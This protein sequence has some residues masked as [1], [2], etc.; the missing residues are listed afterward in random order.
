MK[1]N[2]LN[3][4]QIKLNEKK[5]AVIS[6]VWAPE[7]N[8]KMKSLDYEA[9]GEFKSIPANKERVKK[10]GRAII[11]IERPNANT[12]RLPIR[13]KSD[14]VYA[15]RA[16]RYLKPSK[17][18]EVEP[19]KKVKKLKFTF[20]KVRK[21]MRLNGKGSFKMVWKITNNINDTTKY[22]VTKAKGME[23]TKEAK[24]LNNSGRNF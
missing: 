8:P 7:F 16:A 19:V 20:K 22:F 3:S 13:T 11:V 9:A 5:V 10:A 15:E 1:K 23:W 6:K 14:L 24:K 17:V 2:I 18:K 21:V 12:L 4:N